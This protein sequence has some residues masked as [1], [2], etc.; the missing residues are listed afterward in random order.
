MFCHCKSVEST[1]VQHI[2]GNWFD[3][4]FG[5]DFYLPMMKSSSNTYNSQLYRFQNIW[6]KVSQDYL[7]D[8]TLKNINKNQTKNNPSQIKQTVYYPKLA[9]ENILK[10]RRRDDSSSSTTS[11]TNFTTVF[12]NTPIFTNNISEVVNTTTIKAEEN[13]NSSYSTI[14]KNDN[15]LLS[16]SSETPSTKANLISII[17]SNTVIINVSTTSST[18]LLVEINKNNYNQQNDKNVGTNN[19]ESKTVDENTKFS[20]SF[21]R[22]KYLFFLYSLYCLK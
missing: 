9:D 19:T 20:T 10:R 12:T 22:S 5:V 11:T 6:N 1:M 7:A 16:S 3:K 15:K 13:L 18:M 21:E 4:F 14:M 17:N 8:L 2:Y